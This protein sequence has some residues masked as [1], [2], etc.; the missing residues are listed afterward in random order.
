M[1][2][3]GATPVTYQLTEVAPLLRRLGEVLGRDLAA[4][5]G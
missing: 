5:G 2:E 1:L 3:E 4:K